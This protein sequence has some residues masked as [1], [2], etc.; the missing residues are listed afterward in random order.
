MNNNRIDEILFQA[1]DKD[2]LIPVETVLS[3]LENYCQSVGVHIGQRN[4]IIRKLSE[5]LNDKHDFA[6]QMVDMLCGCKHTYVVPD[7]I[8]DMFESAIKIIE[9]AKMP[10]CKHENLVILPLL[11]GGGFCPVFVL[12]ELFCKECGL[13][14]TLFRGKYVN[15]K[16]KKMTPEDC[17][18]EIDKP[19]IDRLEQFIKLFTVEN[20]GSRYAHK[21]YVAGSN[22]IIAEPDQVLEKSELITDLSE[23]RITDFVQLSE[24][25]HN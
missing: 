4:M 24:S 7:T 20:E 13:N 18:L 9:Q 11:H 25:S 22:S 19:L 23:L 8:R 16:Y 2:K 1:I 12:P 10:D 17:G 21:R 6:E 14:V 5:I 15:D 3:E